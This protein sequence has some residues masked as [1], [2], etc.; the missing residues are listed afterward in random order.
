MNPIYSVL[1]ILTALTI[2]GVVTISTHQVYAPRG[3]SGCAEFKKLTTQF[4]KDVIDAASINPPD[5][6]RIQTLL[7]QYTSDVRAIDFTAG[8]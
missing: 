7:D 5:P 4:E 8:G 2:I 6:D 3:C 1:A